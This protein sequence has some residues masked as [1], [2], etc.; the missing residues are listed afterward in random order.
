MFIFVKGIIKI[1]GNLYNI[2]IYTIILSN[3][4]GDIMGMVQPNNPI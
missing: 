4:D 2:Y 1:F 3:N